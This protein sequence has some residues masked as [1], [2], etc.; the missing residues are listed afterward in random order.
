MEL[1]EKVLPLRQFKD[2]IEEEGLEEKY[3]KKRTRKSKNELPTGGSLQQSL[4]VKTTANLSA[5]NHVPALPLW[6]T[7]KKKKKKKKREKTHFWNGVQ[8]SWNRTTGILPAFFFFF[9]T[10]PIFLPDLIRFPLSKLSVSS[11]YTLDQKDRSYLSYLE[12][13]F[14]NY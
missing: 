3:V 12:K 14:R 8:S 2:D 6:A 7:K 5:S 1:I 13:M 9:W 11:T 10:V 4:L